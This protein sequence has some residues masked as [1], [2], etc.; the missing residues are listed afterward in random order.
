M[1]QSV[2]AAVEILHV[3]RHIVEIQA[4]CVC[5]CVLH[6][7][8]GSPYACESIQVCDGLPAGVSWCLSMSATHVMLC[9][10]TRQIT[11]PDLS[12]QPRMDTVL[13]EVFFNSHR[14]SIHITTGIIRQITT[15]FPWS[16]TRSR[17]LSTGTVFTCECTYKTVMCKNVTRTKT[18]GYCCTH[19]CN[20]RQHIP[21]SKDGK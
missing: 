1:F 18:Q 15:V 19:K 3:L 4:A 21:T 10:V 13:D 16:D 8:P 7:K 12:R 6:E 2:N 11:S 14:D 17:Q 5:V 20:A 9:H